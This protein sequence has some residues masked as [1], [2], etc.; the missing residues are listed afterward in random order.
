MSRER[1]ALVVGA[2]G[3]IGAAVAAR[4][5]SD[6]WA[7]QG[8]SRHPERLTLPGLRPVALDLAEDES[9]DAAADAVS[10]EIDA[11]DLLITCS[12][13][14]RPPDGDPAAASELGRLTSPALTQMIRVNALGPL[15]LTQALV[16]IL[17]R[18]TRALVL[19]LSTVRASLQQGG[20]GKY[21][22]RV[23]KTAL[24]MCV[25]TLAADL[26]DAGVIVVAVNPGWV[27]TSMGGTDAPDAPADVAADL[28]ELL[29][30]LEERHSGQFVDRFGSP[31]P[32]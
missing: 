22:Y 20:K 16:P 24:N 23:S 17:S 30:R 25:R 13:V 19:H 6:G 15:L 28:V 18:S 27:L 1:N 2:S 3:G 8:T 26:E 14:N 11:L 21:G 4:L 29:D 32:W 9:L 31:E 12:G 5:L 10:G 7:V